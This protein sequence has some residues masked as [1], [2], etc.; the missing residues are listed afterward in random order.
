M[1]REVTFNYS[2]ARK[3]DLSMNSSEA[4]IMAAVDP[5][6]LPDLVLA[7]RILC[8]L[9]VLDSHGHVSARDPK[10][11]NHFFLSRSLAPALVTADDIMAYDL[12]A[13]PVEQRGRGMYSE[14]FIHGEIYRARAEVYSVVHSHSP[15]VIPFSI[16][17]TALKPVFHMASFMP[18]AVPV[19]EMRETAGMTD[20]L[21]KTSELGKALAR[22]LG[23][24]TV[25]LLRGHGNVVVGP[26]VRYAAFRAYQT[27]IN[28]RL[29]LQALTLEGP[30]TFIAAEES[31]K[32]F[33][34]AGIPP[35]R[36]WEMWVRQV[37]I[38]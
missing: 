4:E 23:S 2:Y 21:I 13:R 10:Y 36:A 22:K 32:I 25:A 3:G 17:K 30:L 1:A 12:D 8:M 11:P 14:R 27:E 28:A 20:L 24:D 34:G 18:Q 16:S 6:I 19:F 26:D 38:D 15:T 35:D 9:G 7:N 29:Q 37:K 5:T 31:A 33:G